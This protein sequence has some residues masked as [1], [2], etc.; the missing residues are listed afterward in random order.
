MREQIGR[1]EIRREIGRGGMATVY[2]AY[3]PRFQRQVAIKVL[4]RQF[5]HDPRYLARFEQEAQLI[6]KLEHPAIV[7]VYDFGEHE[8]APYLVMRYMAGGSLRERLQGEPLTLEQT[9]AIMERLA[10][11]LDKAHQVGIVHRDIKPANILFD[12]DG[13]LYLADFGLARLA[14][15]SKSMTMVGT[16]AYM[17]PEQVKRTG[18]IDGRADIYALGVVLFELLTGKEPYPAEDNMQ[19]M[20]A[21]VLEPVPD[22]LEAN[23]DLP[24]SAQG[25]IDRTMAKDREE[26]F[27]SARELAQAVRALLAPITG[28]ETIFAAQV[29][30]PSGADPGPVGN[31]IPSKNRVG[32][33]HEPAADT[34]F[35]PKNASLGETWVRP[36]DGMVM[37]YVPEGSF[38]MGSDEG[39]DDE[40]PV[41]QVSLDAY[42]IDR[43]VVTNGQFAT[44]I[45]ATEYKTTAEGRGGS[46]GY[47]DNKKWEYIKGASWRYPRGPG[48]DLKG[49]EDHPVVHVSWEDAI[50]YCEW[51][52]ARLPTEAEWEYAARG[53][54]GNKY[55]WG[56]KKPDCELAQFS[57]CGSQTVPVDSLPKGASWV[58][59][60]NMAGNVWE[61]VNDW[62]ASDYYAK[63]PGHNPQGPGS[64]SYKVLRGGSWGSSEDVLRSAYRYDSVPVSGR[65][66]IG[67]R[68]AVSPG[69]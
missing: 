66:I 11:A 69:R 63:S 58:E 41:H 10:P 20:M 49:L 46:Y 13:N 54:G 28:V 36:I 34:K 1:Y 56:E 22:L 48:S 47:T 65:G 30:K 57:K 61:W 4:P 18:K 8:D 12:E 45:K 37:V 59:A 31:K 51:A 43:T 32:V 25:I 27:R 55:P 42:W 68:C 29:V 15:A 2:L 50:A 9:S 3:D 17:S 38:P 23:P 7:P 39:R 62:Y 60:L 19:K 14:D 24:I 52:G 33:E 35:P 67:F 26:R 40:K 64:G 21:H 5:T 6:A 44:F 53:P 16:P